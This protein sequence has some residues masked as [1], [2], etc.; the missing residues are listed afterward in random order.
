MNRS[1]ELELL[2][3]ISN[4]L[5]NESRVAAQGAG[6]QPVQLDVL[7]YLERCNRYSDTPAGVTDFLGLTKG[8]VSQSILRLEEKGFVEREEDDADRRVS[9]LKLTAEGRR[10][11]RGTWRRSLDAAMQSALEG[12][13]GR[14]GVLGDQ[15]EAVLRAFQRMNEHRSFGVCSSCKFF[16]ERSPKSYRC[17]L[18]R[19]RLSMRDS[20]LICREHD[21]A[22]VSETSTS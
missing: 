22:E 17:G 7:D 16:E 12:H 8:T 3:R 20:G 10:M 2:E 13:G 21:Y 19:E 6:L 14:P 18:T 5:R 4:L 9:H 11:A 1:R 15:L